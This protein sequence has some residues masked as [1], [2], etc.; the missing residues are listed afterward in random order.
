MRSHTTEIPSVEILFEVGAL[1]C[2][3]Y[4]DKITHNEK[5]ANLSVFSIVGFGMMVLECIFSII[6]LSTTHWGEVD[7]SQT[8]NE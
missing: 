7:E 4:F 2:L 8:G 1:I 5:M 6:A 3:C